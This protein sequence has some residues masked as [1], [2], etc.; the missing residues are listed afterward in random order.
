MGESVFALRSVT[1]GPSLIPVQVTVALSMVHKPSISKSANLLNKY[2][3]SIRST[4][5][6]N[7]V[8]GCLLSLQLVLV[9]GDTPWP[10]L[11]DHAK[12]SVGLTAHANQLHRGLALLHK[13]EL[14]LFEQRHLVGGLGD[15]AHFEEV[16]LRLL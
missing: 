1:V 13:L 10:L 16:H 15:L 12:A 7:S 14:R 4:Y 9:K 6:L 2:N 11:E 5:D 8:L 3:Q